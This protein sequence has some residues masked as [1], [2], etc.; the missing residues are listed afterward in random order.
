[1]A[2]Q[3]LGPGTRPEKMSV[4]FDFASRRVRLFWP[5]DD[6]GPELNSCD[7]SLSSWVVCVRHVDESLGQILGSVESVGTE[8]R[9][10]EA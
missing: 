6:G 2:R 1:M 10:L 8:E 5:V 3:S 4:E 9:Y 7:M